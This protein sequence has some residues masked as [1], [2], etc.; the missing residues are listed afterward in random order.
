MGNEIWGVILLITYIAIFVVADIFLVKFIKKGTTLSVKKSYIFSVL[1]F[2]AVMMMLLLSTTVAILILTEFDSI[3]AVPF[4][5]KALSILLCGI[6]FVQI[7]FM[8]G[9]YIKYTSSVL[10]KRWRCAFL[11][12]GI[13]MVLFITVCTLFSSI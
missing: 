9:A 4:F 11:S 1:S 6:P 8:L 10:H 5:V 3:A 2:F 7:L 13:A 12:L